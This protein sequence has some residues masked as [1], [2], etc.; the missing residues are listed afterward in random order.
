MLH[1]IFDT[2][3]TA[4][5]N[6]RGFCYINHFRPGTEC[7]IHIQVCATPMYIAL[8]QMYLDQTLLMCMEGCTSI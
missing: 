7:A 5:T 4:S 3:A 6:A 2:T 8:V 1:N